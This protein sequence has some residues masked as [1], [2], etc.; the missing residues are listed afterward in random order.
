MSLLKFKNVLITGASSGIGAATARSFAR[1][2]SHLI[3]TA[4][5]LNKLEELK[6]ELNSQYPNSKV[7]IAQLDVRDVKSV[8][9]MVDSVP[10]D[11]DK[12]DVLVNNAGLSLGLE[13]VE[14]T[15]LE[16]M[17]RMFDTNVKGLVY[18][19]QKILPKMKQQKSGHI[20]NISSNSG[21]ETY[22]KGGLYCASKF[23]VDAISR[24]LRQELVSSPIRVTA[25]NPGMVETEFS[26]VRFEGDKSKADNVYDGIKPLTAED[27]AETVIF[28]A[29]RPSHV[30][31]SD[32]TIFPKGQ[33]SPTLVHR[34]E[35]V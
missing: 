9:S 1:E 25:I 13:L 14:N 10:K 35:L 34:G 7:H 2:G 32:I 17:D 6:K 23:A 15:S 28:A 8:N 20:I 12:I 24:T 19:V 18:C 21:K 16:H 4:R 26:V 5:R 29:S 30:D 31:I 3:L 33:A 27:I 22:P 11:L